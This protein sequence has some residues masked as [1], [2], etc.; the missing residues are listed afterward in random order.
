M[1]SLSQTNTTAA[2]SSTLRRPRVWAW[3]LAIILGFPVGGYVA[4][5]IVGAVDSVGAALAGAA[6]AGRRVGAMGGAAGPSLSVPEDP[7]ARGAL[8]ERRGDEVVDVVGEVHQA[9]KNHDHRDDATQ[10]PIAQFFQMLH[11]W[12]FNIVAFVIAVEL[13]LVRHEGLGLHC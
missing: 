5:L 11:E 13:L 3:A 12:H 1:T 9:Q 7:V 8:H 6:L 2:T 10:H 4:N